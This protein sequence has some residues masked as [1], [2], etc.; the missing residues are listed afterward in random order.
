MRTTTRLLFAA[1]LAALL[2]ACSSSGPALDPN[3]TPSADLKLVAR[4][5]HFD[6]RGLVVPAG[7]AVTITV[8]N[9]DPSVRHNF[10]VYMDKRA[11]EKI[12]VGDLFEGKKSIDYSFQA[13]P[14]GT[15]FFRCDAH[16]DTMT[17]SLVAK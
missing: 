3:A 14:A 16:P 9:Q 15:Y 5:L 8:D 6:R 11:T 12:F 7:M 4:N 1:G 10:A 2:I 17:G 13:P